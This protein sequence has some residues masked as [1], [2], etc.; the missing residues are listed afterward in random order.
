MSIVIFIDHYPHVN[1]FKNTIQEIQ[2][3]GIEVKLIVQ[4]RGNLTSLVQY[5]LGLPYTSIGHYQPTLIKKALILLSNEINIFQYLLKNGCDVVTGVGSIELTHSAF[6]LRKPSVIFGDDTEYRL[7]YYPLKFFANN[8]VLPSCV[9]A[10]GRNI[11]K[12]NG[13]KELAYLHPNH[14]A[15]K[16]DVLREYGLKANN[17]VFIRE[18]SNSSA[19]YRRLGEGTL[20]SLCPE[21]QRMGF[22]I[23]LSLENKKLNNLYENYC[24]IL[25]EPV[26]DIHS[27]MYYAA[28]TIASGD[29]MAR[30]SCLLGTPA[31]YTGGRNMSINAELERRGCFF[32]SKPNREEML[33]K[34]SNILENNIKERTKRVIDEAIKY[35]WEDTTE[36]MINCLLAAIYKDKS[37]TEK[38]SIRSH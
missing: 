27:L 7:A 17:Y 32:P 16:E 21:I 24:R 22:E 18:V 28:F 19:N 29:S 25:K 23:V 36:V 4:P 37:L 20:V 26:N 14:F 33:S 1:F 38:Y 9:P 30:E 6:I 8:I 34:I 35:E 11:L 31:I 5:E 12:Y 3:R 2:H 13:F 10:K 15:P